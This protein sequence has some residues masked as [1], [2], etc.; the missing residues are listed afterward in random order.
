[1]VLAFFWS[2]SCSALHSQHLWMMA[3]AKQATHAT[4]LKESGEFPCCNRPIEHQKLLKDVGKA[5]K[6]RA[7][8]T[9]CHGAAL[10]S[11]WNQSFQQSATSRLKGRTAHSVII[12]FKPPR[13]EILELC[14]MDLASSKHWISSGNWKQER[15][16]KAILYAL[17]RS[18]Q[19]EK[20]RQQTHGTKPCR[21]AVPLFRAPIRLWRTHRKCMDNGQ[22]SQLGRAFSQDGG[23]WRTDASGRLDVKY[24][25][26]LRSVERGE[27]AHC[28]RQWVSTLLTAAWYLEVSKLI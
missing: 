10:A 11:A 28:L 12:N 7:P 21:A 22:S 24:T 15:R 26:T 17:T 18:A 4:F 25:P 20:V 14:L 16:W 23:I 8:A 2:H 27:A 19:I 13:I 1:M 3:L 5:K 6:Q 9:L